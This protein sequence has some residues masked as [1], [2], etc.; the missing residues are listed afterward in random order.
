MSPS[1]QT[2]WAQMSDEG[3]TTLIA[4]TG[5]EEPRD[6]VIAK[7][8][9]SVN[10]PGSPDTPGE[11]PEENPTGNIEV[12][13]HDTG[14]KKPIGDLLKLATW[15]NTTKQVSLPPTLTLLKYSQ[16]QD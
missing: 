10:E 2:L 13:V 11:D 12:Q 4:T 16:A 6:K 9:E 1:N 7:V 8:H 14:S 5:A 3:C 15:K